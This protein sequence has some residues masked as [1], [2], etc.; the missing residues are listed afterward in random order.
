MSDSKFGV[1]AQA[2]FSPPTRPAQISQAQS[3]L[4]RGA[5]LLQE[6]YVRVRR[7]AASE[8]I[9]NPEAFLFK[10][11]SNIAKNHRSRLE[12]E[13]KYVRPAMFPRMFPKPTR[14]RTIN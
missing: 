13:Q 11:A 8:A 5:G 12:M 4:S 1:L 10:T 7:D 3:R 2:F 9:S 6:T 14:S